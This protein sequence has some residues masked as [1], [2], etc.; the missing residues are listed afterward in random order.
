MAVIGSG[1]SALDAVLQLINIANKIYFLVRS[2]IIRGDKIMIDKV[3]SSPKVEI[4]FNTSTTEIIGDKLVKS[5]KINQKDELREIVV[6]GVL[7][8]IGYI[9]NTEFLQDFVELNSEGEIVIDANKRTKIPSVFAAGDCTDVSY[10]QIIIA[11]GEGS[12]VAISVFDYLS[13]I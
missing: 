9:P 7:I 8:E 5:V 3:K 1:N 12:K 4:L 6:Q 13:K 11:A 2:G 10:K